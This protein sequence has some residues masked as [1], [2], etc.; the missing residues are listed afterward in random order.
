MGSSPDHSAEIEDLRVRL[1]HL[2]RQNA[3]ERSMRAV[4]AGLAGGS[5][6]LLAA[7]NVEWNSDETSELGWDLLL[8]GEVAGLLALLT[9]TVL[10]ATVVRALL[11]PGRR[12]FLSGI[13]GAAVHPVV[14]GAAVLDGS[15]RV[16]AP[17]PVLW[18][19][20]I[21]SALVA[22]ACL[23]G[24]RLSPEPLPRASVVQHTTADGWFLR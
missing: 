11:C 21:G 6:L 14:V 4:T 8:Y 17:G 10:L 23:R 19:T 9:L 20:L 3:V 24:A 18:L 1:D 22:T 7:L 16:D 13:A 5:V 12:V 15:S 2:E